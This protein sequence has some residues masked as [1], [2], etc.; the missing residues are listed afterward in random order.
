MFASSVLSPVLRI[1]LLVASGAATLLPVIARAQQARS[2][3]EFQRFRSESPEVAIEGGGR[4][5]LVD[6][7]SGIGG[8]YLLY[9][10]RPGRGAFTMNVERPFSGES[11][12]VTVVGL[13][14]RGLILQRGNQ[15][16]VC[17]A[18][19]PDSPIWQNGLPRF[20]PICDG[21][22][23][24]R[25][26]AGGGQTRASDAPIIAAA[27]RSRTARSSGPASAAPPAPRLASQAVGRQLGV[28]QLAIDV[29]GLPAQRTV[30]M[31]DWYRASRADGVF[32]GAMNP[33]SVAPEILNSHRDRVNALD[34]VESNTLVTLVALDLAKFDVGWSHGISQ[35]GV[36]WSNHER[37]P[38]RGPGAGPDGFSNLGPLPTTGLLNP[39]YLRD[40]AAVMVGGFQRRD[41]SFRGGPFRTV[42]FGNYFGFI[43]NGVTLSRLNPGIATLYT[44]ADGRVDIKGWTEADNALLPQ[45]RFARQNNPPLVDGVGADGI[46]V[47]GLYV[48]DWAAGAWSGSAA[49]Q[50]RTQRSGTCIVE[51]G[52]GRYLIHAYFQQTNPDGMARVFQAL[53]CKG[54]MHLD[55]NSAGQSY[56]G[57]FTGAWPDV[58][59]EHPDREMSGRNANV[60]I[61]GRTISLPR[62]VGAPDTADFFYFV[63]K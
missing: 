28:P 15:R 45:I 17:P 48:K 60:N 22:L 59:T 34:G 27:L 42:N 41:G 23:T 32:F 61:D 18:F 35:P 46:S 29:E 47:P 56:F 1:F 26:S 58:R 9:L 21:L 6:L 5:R 24:L 14:P 53:Q 63:R 55:M 31:G 57:L 43:E 37:A 54:A 38:P 2:V 8:W 19:A 7:N 44:T 10:D 30:R 13:E 25:P 51:S 4:A 50:K 49:G 36:E 3:V 52:S 16:T 39:T 62:Y 33:G 12:G 20:Y 40:L 11:R